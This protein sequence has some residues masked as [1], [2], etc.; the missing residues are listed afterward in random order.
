M[1]KYT[2]QA[3]DN[4]ISNSGHHNDIRQTNIN[5]MDGMPKRTVIYDLCQLIATQDI[6]AGEYSIKENIDWTLK[7][8][9]NNVVEYTE[10]FDEYCDVYLEFEEILK[11][12]YSD[13]EKMVKKVHHIYR[14]IRITHPD[15]KQDGDFILQRVFEELSKLISFAN[16]D[17]TDQVKEEEIDRTLILIMFYTLTKCKLLEVPTK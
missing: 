7:L 2:S 4:G 5:F 11:D 3:G 6:P 14:N 10:V 16:Y 17:P 1:A 8:N 13:R 15:K 12:Q 9:Y